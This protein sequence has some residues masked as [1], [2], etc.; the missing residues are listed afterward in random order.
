M[1]TLRAGD[2]FGLSALMRSRQRSADVI[3]VE[4]SRALALSWQDIHQITRIHPRISSRLFENLALMAGDLIRELDRDRPH[5]RDELSGTYNATYF[6]DL[7]EFAA[8]EA[9][10]HD[11]D[12]SLLSLELVYKSTGEHMPDWQDKARVIR[13]TTASMRTVLRKGDALSRWKE[14]FFWVLLPGTNAHTAQMLG[15]R[16]QQKL[17]QSNHIL[18]RHIQ[19]RIHITVLKR[20]EKAA[21]LIKR[22]SSTALN[23]SATTSIQ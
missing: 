18:E 14:H 1:D 16:I 19:V 9:N 7:L 23:S 22:A 3:A 12:L 17:Q 20:G 6:V 5:I 2:V 15:D 4:P 21:D 13:K 8:D 11:D 10:R